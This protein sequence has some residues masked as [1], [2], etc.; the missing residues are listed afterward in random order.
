MGKSVRTDTEIKRDLETE[1]AGLA[2]AV[3]ELRAE[4]AAAADIRA[5]LD[6]NLPAAAAAAA[7]VGF[8]VAGGIGATL[9]Y[10]VH[11]GRG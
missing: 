3:A 4:L 9:R 6:G 5:R 11:R 8:V 2:E 7:S 1:R 10:L